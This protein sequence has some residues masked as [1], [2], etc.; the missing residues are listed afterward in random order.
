MNSSAMIIS[1]THTIGNEGQDIV[2]HFEEQKDTEP[3][4]QLLS[5]A[6]C[7]RCRKH[8]KKCNG[9][10]PACQRC[11][12]SKVSG[13]N[14]SSKESRISSNKKTKT[15]AT[16]RGVKRSLAEFT[17]DNRFPV[18][19]ADFQEDESDVGHSTIFDQEEFDKSSGKRNLLS[20]EDFHDS[21]DRM[22]H[23]GVEEEVGSLKPDGTSYSIEVV[24][25]PVVTEANE[26]AEE[27]ILPNADWTIGAFIDKMVKK[28][29]RMA[30]KR[31]N[32]KAEWLSFF[33]DL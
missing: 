2:R 13:C 21:G 7:D 10:R 28:N 11:I 32:E 33:R 20:I 5:R 31:T 23:V 12:D 25:A 3:V 9:G 8:K 27:N 24:D 4:L 26:K 30:G 1:A 14:Y 16:A 6:V 15:S 17:T 22:L 29:S 18:A 19:H